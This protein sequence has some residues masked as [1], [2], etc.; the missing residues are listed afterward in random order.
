M[1][2]NDQYLRGVITS[3]FTPKTR[4]T[5]QGPLKAPSFPYRVL[6]CLRPR[7]RLPATRCGSFELS[8][9]PVLGVRT[10]LPTGASA[11]VIGRL[12]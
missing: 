3:V 4:K 12:S 6:S 11:A 7:E 5:R 9:S 1:A 10:K 2:F 8:R